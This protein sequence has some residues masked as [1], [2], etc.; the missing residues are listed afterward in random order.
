M[1][2]GP[3][4][5][6]SACRI[7]AGSDPFDPSNIAQ[8]ESLQSRKLQATACSGDIPERVASGVAVVSSVG[9]LSDAN[10]IEDYDDCSLHG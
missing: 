3:H 4:A 7:A 1:G 9:R 5:T 8:S 6:P 2:S 10:T